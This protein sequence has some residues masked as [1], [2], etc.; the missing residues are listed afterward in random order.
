[1]LPKTTSVNARVERCEAAIEGPAR[2]APR[3]AAIITDAPTS[4]HGYLQERSSQFPAGA[5]ALRC[6][7]GSVSQQRPSC[8]GEVLVELTSNYS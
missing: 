5:F 6:G 8:R 7:A 4:R 2:K 1:M 3:R